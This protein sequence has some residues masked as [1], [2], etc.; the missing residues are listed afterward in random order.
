MCTKELWGMLTRNYSQ[1]SET[2]VVQLR[3]QFHN[4]HRELKEIMDY[5]ALVKMVCDSLTAVKSPVR[6]KCNIPYAALALN[7]T[8]FVHPNRSCPAY[9]NSKQNY[10]SMKPNTPSL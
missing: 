2:R 8:Y 9:K 6:N 7:I 4:L 10:Y 3:H 5:L 1:V